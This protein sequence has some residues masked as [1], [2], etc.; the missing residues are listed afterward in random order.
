MSGD[1]KVSGTRISG[2]LPRELSAGA[3]MVHGLS[4]AGTWAEAA[5]RFVVDRKPGHGAIDALLFLVLYFVGGGSLGGLRGF[6]EGHREWAVALGA[7]GGRARLMS[8]ASLSRLLH[9]ADAGRLGDAGR[10]WLLHASGA[11]ALLRSPAVTCRDG[12]GEPWHVFDFDP[13]RQ[14]FRQRALPE[15]PELPTGRRRLGAIAAAGYA[16]R[17][18]GE[19]VSSECLLQHHGSGVWLDVSVQPGNGD[20]RGQ[21]ES[22]LA[23]I[24][25]ACGALGV[26]TARSML[27]TD[28]QFGNVPAFTAA[29]EAGVAYLS[30]LSRAELL[31][32][33][34]VR[35]RLNSA[36]WARV[37]DAG[38]GPTRYAADLGEL[39][40]PP[41][42][43]TRRADGS[44]YP[45]IVLRVVVSRY[46]AESAPRG[47]GATVDSE[48]FECFGS[49]GLTAAAWPSSTLVAAYYGRCA[50]E[51]RFAQLD[52]EFDAE[53]TWSAT[54]GGQQLA[55]LALLFVWNKRTVEGA[56]RQAPLPPPPPQ[57]EWQDQASPE[58][59]RLAEQTP[60]PS[61]ETVSAPLSSLA[62]ALVAAGIA[63]AV[64]RRPEWGWDASTLSIACPAGRV[65]RLIHIG[66]TQSF[67]D[68][69]FRALLET[70]RTK[71]KSIRLP[72]HSAS[73]LL[74][75]WA[76]RPRQ[77]RPTTGAPG[78]GPRIDRARWLRPACVNLSA[79]PRFNPD[80]PG[81]LP[82][83]ARAASR[84]Q[85]TH[86]QVWL[87]VEIPPPRRVEEHPLV[88]NDPHRRRGRRLTHRDRVAY[89]AAS[90][91]TA[92]R[93][94][95]KPVPT[96]PTVQVL[97]DTPRTS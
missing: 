71:V 7:L 35:A 24:V 19:L 91:G 44:A 18:R 17:K 92:A 38:S 27:R 53:A 42:V 66:A 73:E 95:H 22:A 89:A 51:N 10:W 11:L 67:V 25:G 34:E 56:R 90:P 48:V 30:R 50:Q 77:R 14:A 9:A 63:T 31:A 41:G 54:P 39:E 69:R 75:A 52:R 3:L 70:G 13:S 40:L 62:E 85:Y 36:R 46:A 81:F 55:L 94:R 12:Q 23:A 87:Y 15:L 83:R 64:A 29:A 59:P 93:L 47:A 74:A 28:G 84:Q 43:N 97:H 4:Q 8:S 96:G 49:L 20:P 57:R 72:A 60:E 37:P 65:H 76:S 86:T 58:L 88:M 21:L 82:A 33:P 2:M 6:Y 26:P 78:E 16:G 61:V 45:P 68:V 5:S 1:S 32:V 79:A 80:W